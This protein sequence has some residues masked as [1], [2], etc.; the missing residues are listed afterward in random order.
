[1][2]FPNE[3]GNFILSRICMRG[4]FNSSRIKQGN[5]IYQ[6]DLSQL[7]YKMDEKL[8]IWDFTTRKNSHV[9]GGFLHLSKKNNEYS[10]Y[11][12]KEN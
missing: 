8:P 2:S 10:F 3:S 9:L 1:M 4:L 12:S 11:L 5:E 6:Q 7:L